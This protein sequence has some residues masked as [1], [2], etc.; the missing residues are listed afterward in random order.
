MTTAKE[1]ATSLL[2]AFYAF[3]EDREDEEVTD[4]FPPL[5]EDEIADIL[6]EHKGGEILVYGDQLDPLVFLYRDYEQ[7]KAVVV[8]VYDALRRH[9]LVTVNGTDIIDL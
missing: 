7:D 1:L 4:G 3:L 2:D 6:D 9:C 5:F 8:T